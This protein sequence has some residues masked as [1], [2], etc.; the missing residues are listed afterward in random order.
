MYFSGAAKYGFLTQPEETKKK[1]D[2]C[3][4]YLRNNKW[5]NSNRLEYRKL[6]SSESTE[7]YIADMSELAL[8]VGIKEEELSKAFM[9]GLSLKLRWHVVSFNPSSLRDRIQ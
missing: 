5:L 2:Q 6:L 7:K 3:S 9:R 1:I 4:D 8:L